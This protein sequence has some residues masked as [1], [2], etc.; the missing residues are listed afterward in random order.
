MKEPLKVEGKTFKPTK[1]G[2][3]YFENKENAKSASS[4]A[5]KDEE[6]KQLYENEDVYVNFLINKEAYGR[7]KLK[8]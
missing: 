5:I 3:I 7:Y 2:Y 6:V 8:N 1:F 4:D